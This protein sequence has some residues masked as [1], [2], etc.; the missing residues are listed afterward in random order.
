MQKTELPCAFHKG[1]RIRLARG[2]YQGT[3][4]TFLEQRTD[5]KWADLLEPNDLIRAHPV[6]WMALD[7]PK[8]N[9]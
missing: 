6:E 8:T 2:S 7:K 3:L 5:P 9:A 1:D 4:G